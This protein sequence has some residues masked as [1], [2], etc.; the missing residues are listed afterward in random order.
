[1]KNGSLTSFGVI[2]L[3]MREHDCPLAKTP[4]TFGCRGSRT[5]SAHPRPDPAETGEEGKANDALLPAVTAEQP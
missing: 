1:M 2:S 3:G 4:G 5:G